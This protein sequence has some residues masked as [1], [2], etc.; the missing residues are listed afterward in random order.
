MVFDIPWAEV[1]EAGLPRLLQFSLRTSSLKPKK[2][3]LLVQKYQLESF[4]YQ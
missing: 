2:L 3:L 1:I 4:V